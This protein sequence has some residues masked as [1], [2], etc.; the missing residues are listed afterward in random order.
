[1]ILGAILGF[2]SQ[3]YEEKREDYPTA[4]SGEC[5][6]VLFCLLLFNTIQEL[7]EAWR[8]YL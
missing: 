2:Y 4:R 5:R 7:E 1:M 6:P 8:D 3:T